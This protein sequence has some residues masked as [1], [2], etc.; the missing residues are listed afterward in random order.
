[1]PGLV[2]CGVLGASRAVEFPRFGGQG[3]IRRQQRLLVQ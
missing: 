2:A 3:L 1:V